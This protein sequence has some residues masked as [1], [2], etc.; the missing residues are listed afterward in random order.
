LYRI[1]ILFILIQLNGSLLAQ[2][3]VSSPLVISVQ[4]SINHQAISYAKISDRTHNHSYI[5]TA[6]GQLSIKL[7]SG[8][9]IKISAI[10][11]HDYYFTFNDSLKQ[12]SINLSPRIYELKE[13]SLSPYPTLALFKKAF[14]DLQLPDSNTVAFNLEPI[15]G[16]QRHK[17]KMEDYSPEEMISISFASPISGLYNLWSRRANSERKYHQLIY[18]DKRTQLFEKKYNAYL[19]KRIT[20]IE[21]DEELAEMM[22]YCSPN[23]EF[24]L[25]ANEYEVAIYIQKCYKQFLALAE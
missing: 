13:F 25:Q 6:D 7:I 10:G 19:V 14:I 22:G 15:V 5:C 4:D 18:T 23:V 9:L 11:Y 12:I 20:G 16:L 17:R 24:I 3:R 21:K 2:D 8:S 1:I